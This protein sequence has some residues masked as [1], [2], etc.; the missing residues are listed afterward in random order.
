LIPQHR[1]RYRGWLLCFTPEAGW[2][3]SNPVSDQR[4]K[5]TPHKKRAKQYVDEA[6]GATFPNP[7]GR[8]TEPPEAGA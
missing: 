4:T 3:G 5:T 1:Q 7:R 8:R 2:W 6:M